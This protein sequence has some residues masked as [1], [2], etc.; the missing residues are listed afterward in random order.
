VTKTELDTVRNPY[1]LT[2]DMAD[3]LESEEFGPGH[4]SWVF[5]SHSAADYEFVRSTMHRYEFSRSLQIHIANRAQTP[6]VAEKYRRGIL[7]SL[8]RCAWFVVFVSEASVESQ[9]VRFEVDWAIRMRRRSRLLCLSID[10]SERR[11]LHPGLAGIR[12]IRLSALIRAPRGVA[13]WLALKRLDR[14]MP[15][16]SWA[17]WLERP[18]WE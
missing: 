6:Q 3:G 17:D 15:F 14:A 7:R 4:P 5:A 18:R 2:V 13:A 12:H 11:A 8:S 10:D 16:G 1:G 9:W